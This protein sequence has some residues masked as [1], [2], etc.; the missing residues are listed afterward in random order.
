MEDKDV[1][2]FYMGIRSEES[3]KGY[4]R[5]KRKK[6]MEIGDLGLTLWNLLEKDDLWN[7]IRL[8][9]MTLE[10]APSL[11]RN[12]A[13]KYGDRIAMRKKEFG[14][15]HDISWNEY[16]QTAK[17]I[18]SALISMGLEKGDCVSIIGDNCPEWVIIDLGIQCSGGIPAGVYAT[19]AW[20]Q[21]EYVIDHSDPNFSLWKTRSNWISG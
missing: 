12:T 21:V 20:H 7:R 3:A 6:A 15:W 8:A 4:Q 11:F 18:G 17:Q 19:N 10:T 2:E 9:M 5:W 1:K 14:L 13:M 16:Y